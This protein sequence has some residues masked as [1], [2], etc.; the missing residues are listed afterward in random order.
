MHMHVK[1]LK[2]LSRILLTTPLPPHL[3]VYSVRSSPVAPFGS[4]SIRIHFHMRISYFSF[5]L[6]APLPGS[7]SRPSTSIPTTSHQ[8]CAYSIYTY[9][10]LYIVYL[11]SP[12]GMSMRPHAAV[13]VV[14]GR[15]FS[16]QGGTGGG[17]SSS[18]TKRRRPKFLSKYFI[19]LTVWIT[20]KPLFHIHPTRFGRGR[21]WMEKGGS[22]LLDRIGSG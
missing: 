2:E 18:T 13:S 17:L 1:N 12:S 9:T 6:M 8:G 5:R 19:L 14:R 10:G 15:E 11:L 21:P 3:R 22:S 16:G 20:S 4:P 7:P